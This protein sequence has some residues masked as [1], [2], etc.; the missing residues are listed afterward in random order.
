MYT[1]SVSAAHSGLSSPA[2]SS[3][4]ASGIS[5]T[6]NRIIDDFMQSSGK[7]EGKVEEA[8]KDIALGKTTDFHSVA[9]TIAKADIHFRLGLEIR[10]RLTDAYQEVMRM[11][12]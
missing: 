6:F 8:I 11:Q 7:D 1:G 2:G 12:V 5:A 3:E 9:M 4:K 10:N